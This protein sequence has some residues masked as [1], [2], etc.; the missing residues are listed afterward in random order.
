MLIFRSQMAQEALTCHLYQP[1]NSLDALPLQ[2]DFQ[3]Y[4]GW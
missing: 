4:I 1:G 2:D 3:F